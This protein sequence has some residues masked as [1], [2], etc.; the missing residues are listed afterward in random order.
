MQKPE[1][2]SNNVPV[3]PGRY[4]MHRN[5]GYGSS[6]EFITVSESDSG[7]LSYISDNGFESRNFGDFWNIEDWLFSDKLDNA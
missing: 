5:P 1:L 2:K 4:Y 6:P 3:E 7:E